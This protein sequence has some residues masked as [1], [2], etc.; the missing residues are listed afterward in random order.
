KTTTT[1]PLLA[2]PIMHPLTLSL[3]PL[4][5]PHQQPQKT[6]QLANII[7]PL[8]PSTPHNRDGSIFEYEETVSILST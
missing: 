3:R 2:G 7:F 1:A 5:I 6:Q 8:I 4:L